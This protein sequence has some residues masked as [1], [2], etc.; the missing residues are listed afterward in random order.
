MITQQM[1]DALISCDKAAALAKH[2]WPAYAACEGAVESGWFTSL[3]Y[4][5]DNNIFGTK[6]HVH[7]IFG[8]HN[9]PTKEFLHHDW[10][11]VN[12]AWVHYPTLADAFADRMQTLRNLA[13][14]YPHYAAALA[15]TTGEEF[16][17]QVS[18]TWS[19]GP[20]RGADVLK[21]YNAHHGVLPCA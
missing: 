15:A 18:L 3:L 14:H 6:Q 12:A 5:Q 4:R 9:L 13:P 20:T 2:L 19:T 8:T 17:T 1:Q 7:P 11:V 16:V 21:I 10:V